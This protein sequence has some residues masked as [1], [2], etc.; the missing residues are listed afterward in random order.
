MSADRKRTKWRKAG[1]L[2]AL[3]P[4]ALPGALSAQEHAAPYFFPVETVHAQGVR[5]IETVISRGGWHLLGREP[6]GYRIGRGT[7]EGTIK[8]FAMALQTCNQRA[9][10]GHG[11]L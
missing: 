5:E 4:A 9:L 10:L 7:T 11:S 3:L 8:P 1:G 2:A 6:R